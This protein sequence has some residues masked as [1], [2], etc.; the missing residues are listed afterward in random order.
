MLSRYIKKRDFHA[1]M[2]IG[3]T[4]EGQIYGQY[5]LRRKIRG[6][7]GTE[8]TRSDVFRVRTE[9]E[10]ERERMSRSISRKSRC[11]TSTMHFRRSM[12][13]GP[14][15]I[16]SFP[17][18]PVSLSSAHRIYVHISPRALLIPRAN[19]NSISR[20]SRRKRPD[21]LTPEHD[22]TAVYTHIKQ[23]EEIMVFSS[24]RCSRE[25]GWH[26]VSLRH[27]ARSSLAFFKLLSLP[28]NENLS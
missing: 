4:R 1:F 12:H 6:G 21:A 25:K 24:L 18:F 20:F 17:V 10:R 3:L 23:N 28:A 26:R 7:K 11:N 9:Q 5:P 2:C 22:S 8:S 14:L 13:P 27:V 19:E 16:L 15:V